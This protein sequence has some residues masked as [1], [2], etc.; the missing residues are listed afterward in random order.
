MMGFSFF[1][2]IFVFLIFSNLIEGKAITDSITTTKRKQNC[3]VYR[4]DPYY[5]I[6]QGAELAFATNSLGC[7]TPTCVFP[8]TSTEVETTTTLPEIVP[9]STRNPNCPMF[10]IFPQY[11]SDQGAELA[12]A[13]NSLGC[14][15]PTC[16]HPQTSTEV[17]TTTTL[18]EIVPTT[19]RNPNC[20]MYKINPQYCS[21]QGGELTFITDSRGCEKPTC[22]FP[23]TITTTTTT[24]TKTTSKII[25]TTKRNCPKYKI[26]PRYCVDKG[27]KLTYITNVIGCKS[28]TCVYPKTKFK[29]NKN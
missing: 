12:F 11:C 20:P 8:Q 15:T 3:P 5:C 24:T 1:F 29:H 18:P 13:T 14:E 27:G 23:Q 25:R 10:R 6:N 28:P 17:E 26:N 16:I 4:I 22:I 9:T 7:E 2:S 21:D 19:T